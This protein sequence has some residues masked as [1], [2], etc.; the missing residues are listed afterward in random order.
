[1]VQSQ[2]KANGCG[3]PAMKIHQIRQSFSQLIGEQVTVEGVAVGFDKGWIAVQEEDNQADNNPDTSEG[4]FVVP[5]NL[6]GDPVEMGNVVRVTGTLV[7]DQALRITD[8]SRTI[9]CGYNAVASPQEIRIPLSKHNPLARYEAMSVIVSQPVYISGHFSRPLNDSTGDFIVSIKSKTTDAGGIV[10]RIFPSTRNWF[11]FDFGA[12]IRRDDGSLPRAGSVATSIEGI[13]TTEYQIY[14]ERHRF[15][16]HK[17]VAFVEKEPRPT[18]AEIEGRLKV[19]YLS[20]EVFYPSTDTRFTKQHNEKLLLALKAL[21]ADIA[22]LRIFS[23]MPD[24]VS[25]LNQL[26]GEDTYQYAVV[27][28]QMQIFFKKDIVSMIGDTQA[29]NMPTYGLN[30]AAVAQSF[31]EVQTEE[32]FTL[33]GVEMDGG[34]Q[35]LLLDW[36]ASNPTSNVDKDILIVGGIDSWAGS[37]AIQTYTNA[38]YIDQIVAKTDREKIYSDVQVYLSWTKDYAFSTRSMSHQISDAY[39]WHV[40]ADEPVSVAPGGM[41]AAADIYRH[42]HRDPVIVGVNLSTKEKELVDVPKVE[43]DSK[44]ESAELKTSKAKQEKLTLSSKAAR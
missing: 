7:W 18:S 13:V 3:E 40:N 22:V 29:I 27:Q 41:H 39:H 17:P 43:N 12:A 8:S 32:V 30:G 42:A 23:G 10:N 44:T 35:Q 21:N 20:P 4:V 2:A 24:L 36:I 11:V 15:K 34:S 37:S 38:N 1:M 25:S 16:P 5:S 33:V 31:M 9:N 26:V 6:E 28:G 14:V 19:A